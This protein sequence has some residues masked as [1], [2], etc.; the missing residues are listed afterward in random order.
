M[1]RTLCEI[2]R[3]LSLFC[4]LDNVLYIGGIK[5]AAQGPRVNKVADFV[6]N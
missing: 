3:L 6:L 2:Q 5:L 4:W 1:A